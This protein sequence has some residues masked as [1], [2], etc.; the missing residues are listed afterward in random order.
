MILE[1]IPIRGHLL[2][3]KDC[4]DGATAALVGM[5]SGLTPIFAE[6]DRAETALQEL[7]ERSDG[8][9]IYLA[10]ISVPTNAYRR[11]QPALTWIL[12]H[13]A[14][15]LALSGHDHVTVDLGRAGSHLLYDFAVELGW[16]APS[17][18]WQRLLD[19]VEAYDL[20]RPRHEAG[21]DLERLFRYRGLSW[22]QE[23]FGHGWVPFNADEAT[24]LATLI[25]EEERFVTRSLGRVRLRS[26]GPMDVA[27]LLMDEPGSVNEISHR[28]LDQGA[29]VVLVIK[30]DGRLSVRSDE[31]VD[32]SALMARLF[33][34]GGHRRA[35]G[36]R[37]PETL[38]FDESGLDAVLKRI[39]EDLAPAASPG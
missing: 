35:A 10:D 18:A 12:D 11:W 15:A 7:L 13:H 19:L 26:A 16:L 8:L 37:L 24:D 3:H 32:A 9:P 25:R 4:L 27:G 17:S 14:S 39:Q 20:W 21:Q 28:L 38:P 31:R 29:A 5:A 2:T 22:Y 33:R 30:P 36:G 1:A 23:R 6:P 34:G